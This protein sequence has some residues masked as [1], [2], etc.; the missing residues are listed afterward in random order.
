MTITN[1]RNGLITTL[2]ACGPYAANE[3]SSCDYGIIGNASGSAIIVHPD[4]ESS[5]SGNTFSGKGT[6]K[7]QYITWSWIGEIYIRFTGDPKKFLGDVYS[8]MDDIQ[9]TLNKDVKLN[10]TACNAALTGISYNIREGYDIEGHDFGVV[11]F[12]LETVEF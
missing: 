9:T 6:T 2:V 12:S 5:I 4:G 10:S 3:V 11:R 7:T 8:A 1:I